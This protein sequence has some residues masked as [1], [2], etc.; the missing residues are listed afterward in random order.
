MNAV[1]IALELRPSGSEKIRKLE[2][3]TTALDR[4]PPKALEQQV[5]LFDRAELEAT[6]LTKTVL[7][8]MDRA[9][10]EFNAMMGSKI[11]AISARGL[12]EQKRRLIR[13]LVQ[14]W[15]Y[16]QFSPEFERMFGERLK[17]HIASDTSRFDRGNKYVRLIGG[18]AEEE[19]GH[20]LWALQDI[21]RLG[22]ED[23]IDLRRDVFPETRALVRSQFDRLNRLS[24]KGFLGYSFYLELYVAKYS[25]TQIEVM[26]SLGFREDQLSFLRYHRLADQGHAADNIELLN[27]L[28]EDEHDVEEV[29]DNMEVIHCLYMRIIERCF[30]AVN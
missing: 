29:L 22:G 20:D 6:P 10:A 30:E 17:E 1:S 18:E 14:A 19:L 11:A 7:V 4:L 12:E 13:Y 24:F 23:T 3:Q 28:L 16:T 25:G 5:A 21:Q 27:F 2:A 15:Y 26:K 8:E 9:H